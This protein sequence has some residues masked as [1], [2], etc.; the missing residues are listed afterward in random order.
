MKT[1]LQHIRSIRLLICLLL[2]VASTPLAAH[3][4]NIAMEKAP[5]QD[6]IWFYLKMGIVHIIP[7]G[8]DHI[9]FVVSLCLLSNKIK[10]ILWQATAF[11]VA[12]SV[13][14]TLSMKGI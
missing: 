6:V 2:L 9:L 12:H 10:A 3:P 7:Y 13:T 11:T 14:L 5:T 1:V 4:V 8:Y